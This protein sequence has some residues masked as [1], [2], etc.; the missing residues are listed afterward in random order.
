[1]ATKSRYNV[2][3]LIRVSG[4]ARTA[5]PAGTPIDPTTVL[6]QHKDPSGNITTL[7]YLVDAA[8]IRDSTGNYHTDISVTQSGD[9]HY[10]FYSTGT[11]QAAEEGI[12]SVDGSEFV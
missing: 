1:M 6:F 10:R 2:G 7:T 9:W 5:G 12:F 11:G 4:T 8:L 3:D